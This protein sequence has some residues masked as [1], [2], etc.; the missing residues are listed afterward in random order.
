DIT[1][2]KEMEARVTQQAEELQKQN[3]QIT[4]YFVNISHDFKTPLTIILL[5]ID[6]LEQNVCTAKNIAVMKQNCYRLGRLILNLLDIAKIDAG[7]FEP[8][9]EFVDIIKQIQYL[10][11]SVSQYVE[12]KNLKIK[13]NFSHKEMYIC[14]DSFI[15]ERIILNLLSNAIKYTNSGG[16]ITVTCFISSDKVTLSVKDTGKGIPADKKE[17]I[18]NRFA[19]VNS[20][21]HSFVDCGIGLAL[22]KSLVESLQGKIWFESKEGVGSDFF[23][24]L[25]ILN[26]SQSIKTTDYTAAQYNRRI[27]I[28]LSD[29]PN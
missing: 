27:Q 17:M 6:L 13:S 25:P 5:S 4:D 18:F 9:W 26:L 24:E 23:V 15:I 7:H 28:E 10:I 21:S 12:N 14:S 29:L 1:D 22:T 3:K 16:Q 8:N 11:E 20:S 2:R 19:Q